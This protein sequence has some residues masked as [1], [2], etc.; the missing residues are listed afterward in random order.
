MTGKKINLH[1]LIKAKKLNTEKKQKQN[2]INNIKNQEDFSN[3]DINDKNDK[4][5]KNDYRN[6]N[7]DYDN[8]TDSSQSDSSQ[9]DSS[10]SDEEYEYEINQ[11]EMNNILNN[12]NINDSQKYIKPRKKYKLNTRKFYH[13][14]Y[15]YFIPHNKVRDNVQIGDII[16]IIHRMFGYSYEQC[17]VDFI[18]EDVIH[19]H[20][21]DKNGFADKSYSFKYK[22]FLIFKMP[23]EFWKN[24]INKHHGISDHET[25]N[26]IINSIK[27]QK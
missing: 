19:I 8:D 22:M 25:S 15:S 11:K 21:I 16:H 5:N 24:V 9:S 2:D 23:S 13:Y 7:S 1:N 17:I 4:N 18:D 14:E 12:L 10:E 27:S 26:N 3:N 20:K 6:N